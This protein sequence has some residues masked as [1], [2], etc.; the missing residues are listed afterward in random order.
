M[1][2]LIY[3]VDVL[4]DQ[5]LTNSIIDGSITGIV[6]NIVVALK[7]SALRGCSALVSAKF[8]SVT[9]IGN[10]ALDGC[11]AL[12]K[13]DFPAAKSID[14]NAFTSCTK[15]TALILRK[16]TMCTLNNTNAFTGTPIASGTGYIYVP[17]ALLDSY[18]ADSKWSTYANQFRRLEDYTVDGTITGE[19]ELPSMARSLVRRTITSIESDAT[20]IGWNAFYFC[21]SLVSAK[22]PNATYVD[23]NAFYSCSDMTSIYL[24]NVTNVN[25]TAFYSC[26]KLK[27]IELPKLQQAFRG[28]FRNCYE[29]ASA[30]LGFLGY[31]YS[32]SFQ[33]C[34]A[35]KIIVLRRETVVPGVNSYV[36]KD[37]PF[38]SGGTGGKCLVPRSL[39]ESYQTDTS[40]S[41]LYA[42]GT[43]TF[44]ALEDYTIDGTITGEIDW[45]KLNGGDANV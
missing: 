44:L 10:Y 25:E 30:D 1:S 13:A 27:N 40:W 19:W 20:S 18:K 38:A 39:I 3:S 9:S 2:E 32:E 37:T 5:A 41:V 24:P 26:R 28:A 35:L 45:D 36:F 33:S 42:A 29:L 7:D 12:T 4:G 22:F 15:L 16:Q 6:D 34:K 8:V 14:N 21:Q 17:G 43:C 31:L 23:N 11:G